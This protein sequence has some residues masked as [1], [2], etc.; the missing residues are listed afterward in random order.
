MSFSV[1]T[2]L[3]QL[4]QGVEIVRVVVI[5]INI[6]VFLLCRFDIILDASGNATPSVY[7]CFLREWRNAKFITL[8]SPLLSNTDKLGLVGGMAQNA[9][10]LALTNL[11]SGAI[12]KGTTVR[13]GFFLP[14][15]AGVSEINDM[16]CDQ[17][18]RRFVSTFGT[19]Y[20]C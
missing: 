6:I 13:W 2:N 8:R 12:A 20:K 17:K 1:V 11:K 3:F 4:F 14:V 5:G 10:D 18:V 19:D 7:L 15:T 9:L 16:V